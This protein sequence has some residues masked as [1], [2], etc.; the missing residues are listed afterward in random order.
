[1]FISQIEKYISNVEHFF[2]ILIT[3]KTI[4][5]EIVRLESLWW[6]LVSNERLS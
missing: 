5:L 6:V 3:D 4:L 1:M 2:E